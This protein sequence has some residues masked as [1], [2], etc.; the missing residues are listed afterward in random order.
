MV[1]VNF[2]LHCCIL[3]QY[4]VG[5]NKCYCSVLIIVFA[6]V[7]RGERSRMT[8]SLAGDCF[9][10]ERFTCW[11]VYVEQEEVDFDTW[12]LCSSKTG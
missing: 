9:G 3:N 8:A 1:F 5:Y 6:A 4:F 10:E 2:S 11:F 7:K 12:S